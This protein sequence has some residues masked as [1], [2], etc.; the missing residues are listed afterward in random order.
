MT[1]AKPIAPVKFCTVAL[2]KGAPVTA[3]AIDE[4]RGIVISGDTSGHIVGWHLPRFAE[5]TGRVPTPT[6]IYEIDEAG[7][8]Y[9]LVA[10]RK[11]KQDLLVAAGA[12][13]RLS[14]YARETGQPRTHLPLANVPGPVRDLQWVPQRGWLYAVTQGATLVAFEIE[15]GKRLLAES[16]DMP[17]AW[18]VSSRAEVPPNTAM[19]AVGGSDGTVRIF[20]HGPTGLIRVRSHN[21]GHQLIYDTNFVF[22]NEF[23]AP[24]LT[25][26]IVLAGSD[27]EVWIQGE[28]D[29]SPLKVGK[30]DGQ[31]YALAVTPDGHWVLTG[32]EA[33]DV[34]M[35][36]LKTSKVVHRLRGVAGGGAVWSLAITS[37]GKIGLIGDASGQV[38]VFDLMPG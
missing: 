18:S 36:D 7:A 24:Y 5:A 22:S 34:S 28:L 4:E 37:D 26:G 1:A 20:Q 8:V 13:G 30:D 31:V 10:A 38:H 17:G 25:P 11:G 27:G 12:F 29:P 6:P 32:G 33:P 14:V 3:L 2:H 21:V 23:V 9:A 19:V 15:T 35:R 16:T